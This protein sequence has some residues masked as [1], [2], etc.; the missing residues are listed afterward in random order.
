MRQKSMN[1]I[2]AGSVYTNV[3]LLLV[4][5]LTGAC[6][7]E[8]DPHVREDLVGMSEAQVVETLGE[9]DAEGEL[10]LDGDSRLPEY[11][12]SLYEV[13]PESGSLRVKELTW[14][15]ESQTTKVWLR[16]EGGEWVAFDSLV[17]S[18]KIRF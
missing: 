5:A 12:S 14:K 17:W 18:Q 4:L 9:P 16:L 11:Q 2:R 3:F 6:K 8:E 1:R 15:T 7:L 10:E 13:I